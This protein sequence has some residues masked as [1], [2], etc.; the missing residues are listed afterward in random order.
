MG[1]A[2][3]H[4]MRWEV[5]NYRPGDE[6]QIL[7][8]FTRVFGHDRSLAHWRWKFLENPAGQQIS[9]AVGEDGSIIGQFAGLPVVAATLHETILLTQGIDHMVDGARRRMGMYAAMARHFFETFVVPGRAAAWYAFPVAEN[10]EI[11]VRAFNCSAL[12]QVPI[13][14]WDLSIA[15]P[16]RQS[17]REIRRHRLERADR[18]GRAIDE[19]WDRCRA[20]LPLATVRDSRYLNWRYAECPDVEYALTVATDPTTGQATGLAV[21]RFGWLDQP[22]APIVDWLVPMGNPDVGR[23]LLARCH[24]LAREKGLTVVQAWFPAYAPQHSFFVSLGYRAQPSPF[25]LS[26][27]GPRGS[28][29]LGFMRDRWY[30]T[31]GDSDIY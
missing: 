10:L 17:W 6:D 21:M 8:L 20:E 14:S 4:D 19:L 11:E 28:G 2:A 1:R 30:Y 22:V 31:M 29:E 15:E 16:W 25:I 27:R 23:L 24:D 12:H 9:L 26:A 5:R 3:N 13:L 18:V 7:G